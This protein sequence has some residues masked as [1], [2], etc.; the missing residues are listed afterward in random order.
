MHFRRDWIV[1]V[2]FG[3]CGDDLFEFQAG[4]FRVGGE[5]CDEVVLDVVDPLLADGFEVVAESCL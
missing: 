2:D 4:F 3:P 1:W 5:V